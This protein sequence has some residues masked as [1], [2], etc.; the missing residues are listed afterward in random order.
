MKTLTNKSEEEALFSHIKKVMKK[1]KPSLDFVK[2]V[3]EATGNKNI[4]FMDIK[5]SMDRIFKF[6]RFCRKEK[7]V[8]ARL[9]A[10][11]HNLESVRDKGWERDL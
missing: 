1:G 6:F 11:L 3:G 4:T 8:S 10:L 9:K 5:F 2:A 7:L